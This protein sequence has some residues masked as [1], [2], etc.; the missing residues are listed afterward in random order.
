MVDDLL[1]NMKRVSMLPFASLL[2]LVPKLVRDLARDCGKEV[3]VIIRGGDIESDR[4]I[5]EELK[6]PLIHVVR[7]CIDHGIEV[8]EERARRAR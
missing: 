4:R 1:E 8:P 7:N 2:E 6:D 5:L 3:E